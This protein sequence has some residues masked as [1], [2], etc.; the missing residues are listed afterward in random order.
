MLIVLSIPAWADEHPT[1][2]SLLD[3]LSKSADCRPADH[4]DL[5]IFT[6]DKDQSLWYVTKPGHPAHPGVI[7]RYV[8]Q[9]AQGAVS[10]AER[11]WSFASDASQPAFKTFLAQIQAL[12]AQMKDVIAAQHGGPPIIDPTVRI[13]GNWQPQPGD[14]EAV[15]SLTRRYFALVDGARYEDSYALLDEIGRASCRERV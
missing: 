3:T 12:D 6:C 1:Y 11:G 4:V 10:I 15:M 7:K 13:Y 5:T 14:S 9:D 8:V 2:E